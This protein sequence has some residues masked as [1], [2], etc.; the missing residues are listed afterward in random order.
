[1]KERFLILTAL[2]ES[3]PKQNQPLLFLGEWC[4]IHSRK[5]QLEGWDFEILDYPWN[6]KQKFNADSDYCSEVIELVLSF[7]TIKQ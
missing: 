6:N 1:M 5:K 3:W 2:E 4:R 7:L